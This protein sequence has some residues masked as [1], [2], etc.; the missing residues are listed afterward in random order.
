MRRQM[1]TTMYNKHCNLLPILSVLMT[2]FES[3]LFDT[4]G[5]KLLIITFLK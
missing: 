2:H 3:H 1:V 5:R 4:L